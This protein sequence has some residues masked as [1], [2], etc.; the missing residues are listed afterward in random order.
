M[1]T[2]GVDLT[3][4]GNKPLPPPPS[5]KNFPGLPATDEGGEEARAFYHHTH[6]AWL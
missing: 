5:E 1:G 2:P 3:T 4:L 6:P